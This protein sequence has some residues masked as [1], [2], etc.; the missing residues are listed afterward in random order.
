VEISTLQDLRFGRFFG[1]HHFLKLLHF[2]CWLIPETKEVFPTQ[3]TRTLKPATVV[4]KMPLS[5]VRRREIPDQPRYNRSLRCSPRNDPAVPGLTNAN[6]TSSGSTP[7]SSGSFR[8]PSPSRHRYHPKNQ[9]YSSP[10]SHHHQQHQ[11]QHQQYHH[12]RQQQYPVKMGRSSDNRILRGAEILRKEILDSSSHD[13]KDIMYLHHRIPETPGGPFLDESDPIETFEDQDDSDWSDP[14]PPPK[15]DTHAL[16]ST[17]TTCNTT[18]DS[19][20]AA[21][22]NVSLSI[23]PAKDDTK[24]WAHFVSDTSESEYERRGAEHDDE[25]MTALLVRAT[26]MTNPTSTAPQPVRNTPRG[27]TELAEAHG[28]TVPQHY[29]VPRVHE[30]ETSTFDSSSASMRLFPGLNEGC[31]PS[32]AHRLFDCASAPP[33]HPNGSTRQQAEPRTITPPNSTDLL[34]DLQDKEEELYQSKAQLQQQIKEQSMQ[35]VVRRDSDVVLLTHPTISEP[36]PGD[37]I[38]PPRSRGYLQLLRDPGFLHAQRAGILWQSI[39][40]QHVRFPAAWWNG[41]RSPPMGVGT[42]RTWSYL[43]RHRVRENPF[44][45]YQVRNRGSPGRL[46]LHVVVRDIMTGEPTLDLA[47]GCFHPNARGIRT[48][49]ACDPYLEGS[50]D[51]WLAI[52][53]RTDEVSV[54]ESLLQNGRAPEGCPLGNKYIVDNRNLRAVFGEM[55]PIHTIFALESELY[56]LFSRRLD[57]SVPPAAILLE[58]YVA[59]W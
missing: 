16:N 58:E 59:E 50:R 46:L 20:Y 29:L 45:Q 40:S 57:G 6:S 48:T 44:L 26:Q 52:R 11:H 27:D 36:E 18:W 10:Y 41:A 56:E 12:Q 54:L 30:M 15:A 4:S 33:K 34:K 23:F 2:P 9:Q 22:Q 37:H 32:F 3:R 51:I 39:V 47:V 25:S 28:Y 35:R 21:D 19:T 1:S 31:D 13:D 42:R 55:P 5:T 49:F 24:H 53:Q 14:L 43:G 17:R 7:S 8:K 38:V